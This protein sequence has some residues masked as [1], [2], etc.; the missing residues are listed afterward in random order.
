MRIQLTSDGQT[1]EG[2]PLQIVTAMRGARFNFHPNGSQ[3]EYIASVCHRAHDLFGT[4]LDAPGGDDDAAQAE[5][6][7]AQLL[8]SGMASQG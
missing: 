8:A 6:F 1:Y 7:V 5:S 2:T 3:A 4:A